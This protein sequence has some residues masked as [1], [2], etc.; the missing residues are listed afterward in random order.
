MFGL[1]HQA[2]LLENVK[3]FNKASSHLQY[4]MKQIQLLL[5]EISSLIKLNLIQSPNSIVIVFL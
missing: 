4:T 5:M 1:V 2:C 3:G